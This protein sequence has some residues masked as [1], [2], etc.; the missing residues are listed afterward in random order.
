MNVEVDSVTG[1]PSF[2]NSLNFLSLN[3]TVIIIAVIV[4]F[5][6]ILM[7]SYLGNQDTYSTE[8]SSANKYQRFFGIILTI[9]F[10]VLLLINGFNYFLNIDIVTSITN[11]F[12]KKP[13]VDINVKSELSPDSGP[14]S[15]PG[16]VPGPIPVPELYGEEVYYVPDNVYTYNDSKALCAAYGGRLANIKELYD[17]YDKGGEW[18]GY[19]WS[20]NQLALFP[21]QYDHWQRL[22]KIKGHEND[23]GRPGVNGGYIDNPN[24]RFGVNCYGPRPKITPLETSLMKVSQDYPMTKQQQKFNRRVEYWKEKIGDIL[25]SPFNSNSWSKFVFNN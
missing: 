17:T 20:E 10:L 9:V 21:T 13:T 1:L 3:P 6:Y 11:I 19:G 16:P 2:G 7:F 4:V 14:G 15:G 25:V 23:C 12:T 5:A 24:V 18:C 22:Q 8:V